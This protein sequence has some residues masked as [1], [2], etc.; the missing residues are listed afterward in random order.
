[1]WAYKSCTHQWWGCKP[2][3]LPLS[4]P[5]QVEVAFSSYNPRYKQ[6][7]CAYSHD[8]LILNKIMDVS[9]IR[10]TY[11][12][13]SLFKEHHILELHQ[14][15][16]KLRNIKD[17]HK[18]STRNSRI[19]CDPPASMLCYMLYGRRKPPKD[20]VS[21][22]GQGFDSRGLHA[23]VIL[24]IQKIMGMLLHLFDQDLPRF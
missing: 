18:N 11:Y 8:S 3:T 17:M 9:T 15:K 2:I 16:L 24:S 14:L 20:S 10:I 22:Q 13:T 7:N 23:L 4:L 1:M 21:W 12:Q 19:T 6:V 5:E